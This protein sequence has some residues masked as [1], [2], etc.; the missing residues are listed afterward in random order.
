[1]EIEADWCGIDCGF[2]LH[3]NCGEGYTEHPNSYPP[4]KPS[5]HLNPNSELEDTSFVIG[6]V[7]AACGMPIGYVLPPLLF[8]LSEQA[9][10]CSGGVQKMHDRNAIPMSGEQAPNRAVQLA[11]AWAVLVLGT[12]LSGTCVVS[13]ILNLV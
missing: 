8:I 3:H 12:A 13:A 10:L 11:F 5:P 6:L 4:L 2:V 9:E 1:M 7:G